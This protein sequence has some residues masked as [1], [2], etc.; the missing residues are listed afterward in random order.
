[1]INTIDGKIGLILGMDVVQKNEGKSHKVR[2]RT[3]TNGRV[4][5]VVVGP[6]GSGQ[7]FTLIVRVLCFRG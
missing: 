3:M 7:C 6:L 5:V 4:I 1:M 2:T